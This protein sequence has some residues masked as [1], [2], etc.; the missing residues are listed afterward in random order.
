ME[1]SKNV[2]FFSP[3]Q[4]DTGTAS[5]ASGTIGWWYVRVC[6]GGLIS[7]ASFFFCVGFDAVS[8]GVW[9]LGHGRTGCI[10]KVGYIDFL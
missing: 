1:P 4:E 7:N 2:L 5:P 6:D 8:G 9:E 10:G 3:P